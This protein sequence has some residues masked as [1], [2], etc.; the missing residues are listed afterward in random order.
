MHT[1]GWAADIGPTNQLG[2]VQQNAHKFGLQT[3]ANAGEPWHVQ[4]AGTMHVGDPSSSGNSEPIGDLF[5]MLKS[6]AMGSIPIIGPL[7]TAGGLDGG[8]GGLAGVLTKFLMGGSLSGM[9]DNA[10][11]MFIKLMTAPIS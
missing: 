11:S 2:W 3:A 6:T 10:I 4:S 8:G 9:I 1:R 5:G 7:L